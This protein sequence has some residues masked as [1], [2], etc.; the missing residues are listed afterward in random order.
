MVYTHNLV[1]GGG[2]GDEELTYVNVHQLTTNSISVSIVD[3]TA[4]PQKYIIELQRR[5]IKANASRKDQ[6]LENIGPPIVVD[7]NADVAYQTRPITGLLAGGIYTITLFKFNAPNS[8]TEVWKVGD[9]KLSTVTA[10]G[11]FI[12][13][14]SVANKVSPSKSYLVL[15]NE[16][17][18]ANKYTLAQRTFSSAPS[19]A[20]I[21]FTGVTPAVSA[22]RYYIFGTSILMEPVNSAPHQSAGIAFFLNKTGKTGYYLKIE[23]TGSAASGDRNTVSL[24]YANG[25]KLNRI[26]S[27][28]V[29][30]ATTLDKV[31]GGTFYNIDIRVKI[32]YMQSKAH[33][34]VYINGFKISGTHLID[35]MWNL[36]VSN[37]VGLFVEK[38]R[39]M[40][41]YVYAKKIDQKVYDN[42]KPDTNYYAGQFS[43][44]ILDANFGQLIYNLNSN[45]DDYTQG[46]ESVEEFGKVVREIL[47]VKTKLPARPSFPLRW[48]VGNNRNAKI[49]A[50]KISNFSAEAYVLNTASTSIPL[51]GPPAASFYLFGSKLSRSGQVEYNTDS[52]DLYATTEPLVFTS[53][54]IQNK[55]D[56]KRIAEWIKSKFINR[57]KVIN[58]TTFG[59]PFLSPGDIVTVKYDRVGLDGSAANKFVVVNVTQSFDQGLE[60]TLLCRSL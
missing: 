12:K 5:A 50:S 15:S 58:I 34:D 19:P 7:I 17:Q 52:S 13:N 47:Y 28:Q 40:F 43:N 11:S 14:P 20:G 41:D 1:D 18:S 16:S 37:G 59:N 26:D 48:S 25:T 55:S 23:G 56:A 4:Q 8:K 10:N 39:A 33:I 6:T 46:E 22:N 42:V 38:G 60:T 24:Y 44:D 31:M 27:S 36:N 57:G 49:I 45:E 51:Q 30:P 53:K 2:S 9:Y 54:W 32:D 29:D 21:F 35:S 3:G